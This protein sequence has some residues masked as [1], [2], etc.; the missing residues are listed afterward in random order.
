MIPA[1]DLQGGLPLCA[2]RAMAVGGVLSAFGTLTFQNLVAR[3]AFA[4]MTG[5]AVKAVEA[6]LRIVAQA[7]AIVGVSDYA[8][9]LVLQAGQMA[10]TDGLAA[11]LHAV[12]AVLAKTAFGHVILAQFATLA[13]LLAL[14]FLRGAAS[15]PRAAL[16]VAA[17]AVALQAGHSHAYGMYGGPSVLLWCD[18]LHLLGAGAWLGGLAPL[19]L[20]VQRAPPKA[21]AVAARWFSPLGK[22]CI[23]ALVVSAIVQGW[24]LVATLPGLVGTAYG[25]MV[26]VKS[27]LFAVLL[28]FAAA[29]RYRFAPALLADQAGAAK[30][31]LIR[32]ILLQTGFA[33]AIIAAAIVLSMLP[34]AMHQQ[35]G[36][37]FTARLSLSAVREDPDFRREVVEALLCLAAAGCVLSASLVL[38]RVR[39][40]ACALA[41]S[42]A[43]FAIPHLDLLLVPAYP[44]SFY[45]SPTGFAA[46][47]IA[48]GSAIYARHCV[49]CHGA[50]G[51][52]DGPLASTLPVPPA[53][54]TADHLWMH[55][56][57]ELFWWL[58]HGMQ[59][60]EGALAMPGFAAV[61]G[62]DQRWAA[63]DFIRARNAGDKMAATGGWTPARQA[64]GFDVTCG[65]SMQR[66][67]DFRGKFVL[68]RFGAASGAPSAP[69][70]VTILA[71][72]HAEPGEAAGRCI[73]TDDTLPA[74]YGLIAGLDAASLKGTD[75]LI[76]DNG[77]LRALQR[78][79][80]A[81]PWGDPATLEAEI[82]SLRTHPVAQ[83]ATAPM[84]MPM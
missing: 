84:K 16:G 74:A 52:G 67:Q 7:S 31:V 37:P 10:E 15:R 49:A 68:L 71:G 11:S 27:V 21:G 53:D 40:A 36:W 28:G 61:L 64:P 76:D 8:V 25:W 32:S 41:A 83:A 14:V 55:S 12:P 47:S 79:G 43:W 58:S 2:A 78:P 65:T 26:L 56:D 24:V 39:L 50:G 73:S 5:D 4:V 66:L 59:T 72:P 63:I 45:H 48:D 3:K 6:R 46:S 54:L 51:H 29:N 77:M 82:R 13:I 57:G 20:L 70:V 44:T 81:A 35:P 80:A 62:E 69:G 22:A 30:S 33:L 9:W 42:F 75:F 19:L 18:V 17:L 34:P 38:R 1:F 23:A 60:P